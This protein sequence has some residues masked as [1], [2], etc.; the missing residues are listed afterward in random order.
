VRTALLIAGKDLRQRLR[1]RSAILW[2]LVAPFALAAIFS[3][4][5][6]P[7]SNAEFEA[8]YVLVDQD[9]GPIAQAFRQQLAGMER[10]GAATV[11]EVGSVEEARRQVERGSD[12]FAGGESARADAAFVLPAGFSEGVLSG[13]GAEMTL[14]GARGSELAAQVAYSIARGFGS[15]YEAVE[16]AVKTVLPPG[17]EPEPAEVGRLAQQ[18]AGISN[19]IA[20]EDI[21]ASTRQLDGTT[22]MTAGMAVFFVFFTVQFGVIGLLEERR[23]GTMRRLLAAPIRRGSIIAGKAMTA[24]VLGVVSLA[25][26]AVATTFLLG[27]D[28]GHPLGVALL[29]IAVVVAALGILAVV[30]SFART[31]EQAGNF[32][33]IIA[34]V[35]G[36]LGGSFFPVAQA[37]GLLSTLSLITPHAWFMRG[38]GDLAGGEVSAVLPSVMALLAFGLVTSALSW[39]FLQ[40]GLLR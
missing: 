28:W 18:A 14:I 21:S 26:L 9:G 36:L 1:D 35:F 37:G 7:I 11:N 10:S 5:F 38:L 2:G 25:V 12:P 33:A 30:A 15:E 40:R 29:I 24:F 32:S 23:L 31:Q 27:A 34:L 39:V 22:Q 19:P 13:R 8:D 4:V 20:V 16:L 3:F 6:T 17:H